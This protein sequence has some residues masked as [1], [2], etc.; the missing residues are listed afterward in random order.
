MQNHCF[1]YPT[2]VCPDI[3]ITYV[4]F[5]LYY[6]TSIMFKIRN[7]FIELLLF[8]I[9]IYLKR[10]TKYQDRWDNDIHFKSN[11]HILYTYYN[12]SLEHVRL[13]GHQL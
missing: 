1:Y 6:K 2:Q 11:T 10:L 3:Y 12:N 5:F 13:I 9:F 4:L 7:N 8:L